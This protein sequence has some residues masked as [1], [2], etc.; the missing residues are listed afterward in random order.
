MHACAPVPAK[1]FSSRIRRLSCLPGRDA[2][3]HASMSLSVLASTPPLLF[4]SLPLVL[5]SPSP[6]GIPFACSIQTPGIQR[7]LP[8]GASGRWGIFLQCHQVLRVWAPVTVAVGEGVR[9]RGLWGGGRMLAGAPV[10]P[11]CWS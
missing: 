6:E 11:W 9:V 5:W 10:G 8:H 7:H 2:A 3:L 4:L 1:L